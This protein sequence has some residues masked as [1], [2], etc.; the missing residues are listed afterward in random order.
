[1]CADSCPTNAVTEVLGKH[2]IVPLHSCGSVGVAV[3][4]RTVD[5]IKTTL[6]LVQSKIEASSATSGEV[7]SAPFDVEDAVGRSATN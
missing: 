6:P 2:G 4:Q 3:C 5:H 7:L 1:L